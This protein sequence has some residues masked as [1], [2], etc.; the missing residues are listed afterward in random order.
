MR[1]LK[2]GKKFNRLSGERRSF[3]RNLAN[4]LVRAGRIETTEARAKAVRPIVERLV[5]IA[6]KQDLAARRLLLMRVHNKDIAEKLYSELGP[7]YALRPGG[8]LR[9]IKLA[10]SRKRDGSRLSAVEFV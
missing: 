5:S 4:D 2:K 10:R 1:H 3:L 7:R 9:I 6:K 8:Y